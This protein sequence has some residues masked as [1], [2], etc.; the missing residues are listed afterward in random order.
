MSNVIQV[1]AQMG[2]DAA[3]Q[4]E[5]AIANLLQ[6]TELNAELTE[7]IESKDIISLERQLDVRPDIVCTIATPEGDEDEDESEND[8][9]S[10][11]ETS[12]YAIGF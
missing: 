8:D 9:E 10:A 2:C 5:E 4:S 11:E 1:L 12:N 7:A 3:L 6:T